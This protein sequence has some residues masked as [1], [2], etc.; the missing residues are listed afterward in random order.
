MAALT[1]DQ[2][3]RHAQYYEILAEL[4]KMF[5]R[6]MTGGRPVT[7]GTLEKY[8]EVARYFRDTDF[9]M[10]A[11]NLSAAFQNEL[12]RMGRGE[13]IRASPGGPDRKEAAQ[14]QGKTFL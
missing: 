2:K 9:A 10:F 1:K 12:D 4:W 8:A 14:K 13:R 6:D 7:V 5:V 11:L 3:E